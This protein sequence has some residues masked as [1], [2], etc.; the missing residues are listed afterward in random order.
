MENITIIGAGFAGFGAA[1]RA[2]SENIKTTIFER[3]NYYGGHAASF[4]FEE[5]FIFDDGPH[6]SFT[7]NE[8]MQKLFAESVNNEYET[9]QAQVNNYWN[10]HWIKH[11]AQCN[12][13]GLPEDLV[14]KILL[15]F[16]ELQNRTEKPIINNYK[17]WLFASFGK[18]FAETFPMEYGRKFHTTTADNMSTDWVGP[19]LYQP[20]LE[21]IIRGAVSSVTPEV[22]YINHF[23]YPTF[24][25]YA[26]YLTPYPSKT[27]I[28]FNHK[29]IEID[30][31][32]K[33]LKFENGYE[34]NYNHLVS[35]LPLPAIISIIKGVPDDVLE[36]SQKLTFTKCAIINIGIKREDISNAHWTYFY[37]EDYIFSRLSFPHMLSPNTVPRGCGS[38][39]AE[40]YFSEKYKPMTITI[41]ECINTTIKDLK[42]CGLVKEND[43][44]IFKKGWVTPIAQVIFDLNRAEALK[45]VHGYLEDLKI[46]YCGRYGKWE[47]IWTDESFISGEDA[48]QNILDRM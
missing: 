27:E 18:T 22:H 12:L 21:E 44:I 39:Q 19:R 42:R 9:I 32:G 4:K 25:G 43:E 45:I 38:I 15:E 31:S 34:T 6:I 28:K 47:Y 8:R 23:R 20:N 1:Y 11:P 2:H 7:K 37:D 17:D 13:F 48:V 46:E 33:K 30:P 16:I 29:L 35:S 41:D 36:A 5:G 3:N 26:N 14:T 40:I 24:E 10:G